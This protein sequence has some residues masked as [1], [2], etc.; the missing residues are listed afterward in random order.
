[1][2]LAILSLLAASCLFNSASASPLTSIKRQAP[3][4]AQTP[5]VNYFST[6]TASPKLKWVS[7]YNDL[8][9]CARLEVPLN[10]DKPKGRKVQLAIVKLPAKKTATY[11]GSLFLQVGLGSPATNLVL[12]AGGLFQT[13][14]LEGWDIIGWDVRGVG[15]TRPL[16]RCF[17]GMFSRAFSSCFCFLSVLIRRVLEVIGSRYMVYST[18]IVNER[19]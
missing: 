9:Q 4:P 8:Y 2:K 15:S 19:Y 17:P 1:M 12:Q 13:P 18:V 7:C 10:Y 6:L 14:T 5:D 3:T 16:L 11:K